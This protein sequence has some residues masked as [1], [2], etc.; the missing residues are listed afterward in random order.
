M[1]LLLEPLL[2]CYRMKGAG[3]DGG[4]GG[5]GHGEVGG[6]VLARRMRN[7]G[8]E[9]VAMEELVLRVAKSSQRWLW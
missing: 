9:A 5:K 4:G 6:W 8:L 7:A 3:G 1:L 2:I